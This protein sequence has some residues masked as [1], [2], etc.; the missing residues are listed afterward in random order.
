VLDADDALVVGA[1]TV[2]LGVAAGVGD[3]GTSR[4][5]SSA[6]GGGG[7]CARA[8][9]DQRLAASVMHGRKGSLSLNKGRSDEAG[10][11]A[12]RGAASSP[13]PTAEGTG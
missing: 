11:R 9:A 2:A 4:S 5:S 6:D 7:V 10:E 3:T 13:M 12:H 8:D 1:G